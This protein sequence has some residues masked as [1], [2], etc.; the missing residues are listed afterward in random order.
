M[1]LSLAALLIAATA[2]A[3]Q[4]PKP[5]AQPQPAPAAAQPQAAAT[6]HAELINLNLLAALVA[7]DKKELAGVFAFVPEESAPPAFADFLLRDG[8]SLK[9]FLKK[10]EKDLKDAG[11]V[12]EWDQLVYRYVLTLNGSGAISKDALGK[13]V[14]DRVNALA[15]SPALPLQVITLKRKG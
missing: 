3:A 8:G 10:S 2:A 13:S 4:K 9:R 5:A 7:V 6:Q 15:V 12:S 14:L 11:G 1:R